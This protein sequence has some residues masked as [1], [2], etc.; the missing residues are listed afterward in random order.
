M[1]NVQ[2]LKEPL[3]RSALQRFVVWYDHRKKKK[4]IN[5]LR[6]NMLFFGYDVSDMTD[7]EIETGVKKASELFG[8]A[9][10]TSQQAADGLKMLSSAFQSPE[11]F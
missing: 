4:A 1:H 3:S 7:E 9:G 8:K 6:A 2:K 5:N 11:R 10:V